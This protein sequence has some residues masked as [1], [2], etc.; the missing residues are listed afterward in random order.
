[1]AWLI[2]YDFCNL[3][4][5]NWPAMPQ[6]ELLLI[7]TG[8]PS[9]GRMS[10]SLPTDRYCVASFPD[11]EAM[12]IHVMRSPHQ[13]TRHR[14]AL[15]KQRLKGMSGIE[16]QQHLRKLDPTLV[17]VIYSEAPTVSCVIE[18][19]RSGADDYL[20]FPF[21][22]E[23]LN[24]SLRRIISKRT[25]QQA[26]SAAQDDASINPS[27]QGLTA[28]E[29]DIMQLIVDGQKNGQICAALNISL[30]T[31]KMHRA[32]LMRKLGVHNAAQLTTWF[33][34]NIEHLS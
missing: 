31:V 19:W 5:T 25:Q 15:L 9:L 28:R 34:K 33:H 13:E 29:R 2:G 22:G 27:V 7:D 26:A 8:H 16:A 23:A 11:A 10:Q 12:L 3:L 17:S 18:A 20:P 21:D 14:C 30:A 24:T 1:M 4:L 32:N 6:I